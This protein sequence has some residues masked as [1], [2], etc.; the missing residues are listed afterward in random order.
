MGI[1]VTFKIQRNIQ[2]N[3]DNNSEKEHKY[4]IKQT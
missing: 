1:V 2:Q 3:T 4:I